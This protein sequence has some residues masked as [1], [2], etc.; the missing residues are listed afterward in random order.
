MMNRRF[1][2]DTNVLV[3]ALMFGDSLPGRAVRKAFAVGDILLSRGTALELRDVLLRDR[4]ARYLRPKKA[5]LFLS[6]LAREAVW[7][8][9]DEAVTACRGP[10]DDVFLEL[11]VCGRAEALVTRDRDLLSLHPFGGV[12]ILTPAEFLS[13]PDGNGPSCS[14]A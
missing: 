4:L 14:S 8:Q 9:P 1:V 3:S 10:K 6:L 2:L 7:L 12:P 13:L 11:A 5:L